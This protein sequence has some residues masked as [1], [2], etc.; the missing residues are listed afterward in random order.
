MLTIPPAHLDQALVA[1]IGGTNARFALADDNDVSASATLAVA[2]FAGP[3]EA[4]LAFLALHHH[5]PVNRAV[6]ALAAPVDG[7][8]VRLTNAG[9]VFDRVALADTLELPLSAVHL[10]NDFEA[11]ALA[12]PALRDDELLALGDGR[13]VD[14]A[15]RLVLGPGTGLG[16][17]GL[18]R[19]GRH[20]QALPGEGGHQTLAA[21]DERESAILALARREFSHVS[22]ERLLSGSGLPLLHRLLGAVEGR[23]A[24][25]LPT[26]E[27]IAGAQE[28]DAA[29]LS[30]FHCF[31]GWLGAFAGN[32]ALAIGARGG[33]YLGGGIPRRCPALFAASPFRARFVAKG[34]FADYLQ[35]VPTHLV[36]AETPALRGA[37]RFGREDG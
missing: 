28:G 10:L 31:A 15:P 35:G 22:A 4:A 2:D 30:T 3:A 36:L 8:C 27:I 6:F 12:L 29:C 32:L 19:A 20:W 33:V 14:A 24:A 7:D 26:A 37:A 9:W 5:P 16:V 25:A 18:L 21:G 17:A 23:S 1:D 34:R 11:L 13:A